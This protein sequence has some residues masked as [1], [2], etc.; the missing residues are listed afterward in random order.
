[1]IDV[2]GCHGLPP[3][4]WRRSCVFVTFLLEFYRFLEVGP[5]EVCFLQAG[6]EGLFIEEEEKGAVTAAV[7]H[8]GEVEWTPP[9]GL[10]PPYHREGCSH[11]AAVG[12]G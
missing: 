8:I 1:M 10:S 12:A 3:R 4:G 9:G 7:G 2:S 11:D 5:L 6:G